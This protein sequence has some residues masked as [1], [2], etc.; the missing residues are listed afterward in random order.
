MENSIEHGPWEDYQQL[1]QSEGPWTDF[2]NDKSIYVMSP[3]D[4]RR[5]HQSFA[6]D[7][8]AFI[9]DDSERAY[10]RQVTETMGDRDVFRKRMA[11]AAYFTIHNPGSDFRFNLSNLDGILEKFYKKKTTPDAAYQDLSLMLAGPQ[12]DFRTELGKTLT[13]QGK[14]YAAAAGSGVVDFAATAASSYLKYG[15]WG[16]DAT[17]KIL[18]PLLPENA[19]KFLKVYSDLVF[20][21]YGREVRKSGKELNKELDTASNA[22]PD[23]ILDLITGDF[24]KVSVDDF[25]KALIRSTPQ[26]AYQIGL[27]AA[28]PWLAPTFIGAETL[29]QKDYEVDEKQPDWGKAKRLSYIGISAVNEALFEMVTAK[30]AGGSLTR[31]AGAKIIQKGLM[32]YLGK[33]VSEE[34][35]SEMDQQLLS[36]VTD[37]LYNIDGDTE[38]LSGAQ[39]AKRVFAGVLESGFLGGVWGSPAG[40]VGFSSARDLMGQ[41]E[42]IRRKNEK[43]VSELTAKNELSKDETIKLETAQKILELEEPQMIMAADYTAAIVQ[44]MNETEAIRSSEEFQKELADAAPGVTE[45]EIIESL[46]AQRRINL[47]SMLPHNAQEIYD[48]TKEYSKLF[49]DIPFVVVDDWSQVRLPGVSIRP[50]AAAFTRLET[51]E[52]YINANK[53]RPHNLMAIMLHEAIGHKGLRAVVPEKDLNTLLDQVYKDHFQDKEFERI[54]ATYFEPR[55]LTD[56]NGESYMGVSL[57]TT[58]EQ[59]IAAEEYIAHLAQ[60][61]V[62]KPSWWKEFLQK[63]RMW[64]SNTRFGSELHMTDAQIETLLARAARK[65]RSRAVVKEN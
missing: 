28:A 25:T 34:S 63:I 45:E 43:T 57:D 62:P 33:S 64:W 24:D 27:A 12:T 51:G 40:F 60:K 8:L 44:E 2:Q 26:M 19:E 21:R 46:R 4:R 9:A 16:L 30:I 6:G 14:E 29:A 55:E 35:L 22:N 11:L 61:G 52:I 50:D 49:K 17:K 7:P 15:K 3:A 13:R 41:V 47:N 37:L 59:R 58:E 1:V 65:V 10:V 32:K 48:R 5:V 42:K 23:F 36:N 31:K 53:V 39:L 20:G 18:A 38:I 56:E 54:A